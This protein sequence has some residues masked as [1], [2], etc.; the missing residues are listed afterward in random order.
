MAF[1]VSEDIVCYHIVLGEFLCL[2]LFYW[3]GQS[4]FVRNVRYN[5][6]LVGAER[7]KISRA[8]SRATNDSLGLYQNYPLLGR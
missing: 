5:L 3:S 8:S 4:E 1:K 2:S 6:H 7:G